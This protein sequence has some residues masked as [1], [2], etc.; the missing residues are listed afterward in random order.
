MQVSIAISLYSPPRGDYIKLVSIWKYMLYIMNSLVSESVLISPQFLCNCVA[1]TWQHCWQYLYYRPTTQILDCFVE[2]NW[3][4]WIYFVWQVCQMFCIKYLFKT[5]PSKCEI[6]WK[7]MLELS[8]FSSSLIHELLFFFF[9]YI[10]DHCKVSHL[11]TCSVSKICLISQTY[12]A[13]C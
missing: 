11:H 8:P 10:N 2:F 13:N 6:E 7:N 9:F 5:V 4:F 3:Y 1:G 12:C